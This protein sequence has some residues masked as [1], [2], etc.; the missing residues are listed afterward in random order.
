MAGIRTEWLVHHQGEAVLVNSGVLNPALSNLGVDGESV[1]RSR[2]I[3]RRSSG[4]LLILRD[5][6]SPGAK[7]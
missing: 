4:V 6:R 3:N 7:G 5:S 2:L 1:H